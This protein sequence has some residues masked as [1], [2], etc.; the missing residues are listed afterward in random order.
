CTFAGDALG[1]APRRLE[2]NGRKA[3]RSA[4]Y[5]TSISAP[6]RIF[7]LKSP[8]AS[9]TQSGLSGPKPRSDTVMGSDPSSRP[10]VVSRNAKA[11]A[12]AMPKKMIVSRTDPQ[13]VEMNGAHHHF[14]WRRRS[15][16]FTSSSCA[17]RNAEAD[18]IAMRGVAS[19]IEIAS[20]MTKPT[21]TSCRAARTPKVR[22]VRSVIR[23]AMG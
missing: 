4:P 13:K 22:L 12:N 9:D 6:I 17:K 1:H 15:K 10:K 3:D 18:A 7:T 11:D 8:R 19:F 5:G 14:P 20:A 23:K 21:R 2:V 16:I